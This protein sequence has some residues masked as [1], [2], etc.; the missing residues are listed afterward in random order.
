VGT[1]DL[2]DVLKGLSLVLERLKQAPKRRV[3]AISDFQG[4]SD[5]HGGGGSVVGRLSEIYMIVGMNRVFATESAAEH[6]ACAIGD[7]LVQVH[8]GLG[9]GSG[10]PHDQR[11]VT[12]ELSVDHLLGSIGDGFGQGFVEQPEFEIGQR[13][14]FL[15]HGHGP[16]QGHRYGLVADHEIPARSLGLGAPIPVALYVDRAEGIRFR[17]G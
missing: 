17:A 16:D 6:L 15:D 8:V 2:D 9:A 13:R 3:E 11:E 1:A 12:V 7:H 14:G 5:M 10:L 4:G